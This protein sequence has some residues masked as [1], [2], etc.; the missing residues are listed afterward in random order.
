MKDSLVGNNS[1]EASQNIIEIKL[2]QN[3]K[4]VKP[5]IFI[6]A[7]DISKNYHQLEVISFFQTTVSASTVYL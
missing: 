7:R 5:I 1:F 3:R 2:F 6:L 4:E